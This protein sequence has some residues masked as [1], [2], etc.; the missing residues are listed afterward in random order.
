VFNWAKQREK[1]A[2]LIQHLEADHSTYVPRH[3]RPRLMRLRWQHRRLHSSQLGQEHSPSPPTEPQQTRE[4]ETLPFPRREL[5][6]G[7]SKNRLTRKVSNVNT[8]RGRTKRRSYP[9]P[10]SKEEGGRAER[11]HTS[12]RIGQGGQRRRQTSPRPRK[13]ASADPGE[14]AMDDGSRPDRAPADRRVRPKP[15]ARQGRRSSS[16]TRQSRRPSA[17][18]PDA[19]PKEPDGKRD[20]GDKQ[21]PKDMQQEVTIEVPDLI[22][23]HVAA[24]TDDADPKEPDRAPDL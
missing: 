12:G 11:D 19:L 10:A 21:D 23:R 3:P 14:A 2:D 6:Q 8:E 22:H 7:S 15:A 24:H 13:V 1:T 20:D 18:R 17:T 16:S 5:P 4:A 9:L